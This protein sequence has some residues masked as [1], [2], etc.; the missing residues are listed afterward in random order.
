MKF[1]WVTD[2]W[3]TLDHPRDTTLRLVEE[4]LRLGH[5]AWWCDPS[6]PRLEA[7]R[8][9]A[10][11]RAVRAAPPGRAAAGWAL[12]PPEDQALAAFDQVHYRPDP[13]VDRR[14]LEHLQLLAAGC[15]GPGAPELVNPWP[16]LFAQG[17]KLGPPSL[18]RA[19]P[20]TVV[21]SSWEQLAAFGRGEGRTV[22]KPLGGAQS[23]GVRLLDW[24]SPAGVTAARE[25]VEAASD[26]LARPVLLQ[27]YLPEVRA[28]EK[29]LWFVDGQLLAYA[30]K[31]PLPG[32]F[33][34][35]MDEGS[36]CEACALA[37]AE[38]ALA[39]AVGSALAA[40]GVRLAAIDLIA[41]HVT[42]WNLTSPGLVP[43]L[44][45][46][47]GRNLARPIVQSLARTRRLAA[48]APAA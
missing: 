45:D 41:G 31:R 35:N 8:G 21:S 19:L 4:A 42:D 34:V 22:L 11:V 2:P 39:D 6:G 1:L 24:T 43:L 10:L 26:G 25:A 17:D 32:S 7:G 13:P 29:R 47:L 5:E 30:R 48:A 40:D 20:P 9:R 15:H 12:G 33:L 27:R 14:Y 46:V 18:A 36:T 38:A 37:P 16:A 3:E 28:G 23:R 44:E